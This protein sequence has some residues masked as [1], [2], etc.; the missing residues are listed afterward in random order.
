[1]HTWRDCYNNLAGFIKSHPQ[2]DI[3][4]SVVVI[5]DE[6]RAEFYD[7]F[8]Q[9]RAQYVKDA[10]PHLVD[11]SRLGASF[12]ETKEKVITHLK[13]RS[14]EIDPNLGWFLQDP[15][16]GLARTLFEPLFTLLEGKNSL[17]DFEL[18]A[19]DIISRSGGAW[20]HRGYLHWVFLALLSLVSPEGLDIVPVEDDTTNPDLTTADKRPGWYTVEVPKIVSSDALFLDSSKYTPLLVPKAVLRPGKVNAYASIATD[21]RSVYLNAE[22]PNKQVEWHSLGHLR[23]VFGTTDLWPDMALFVSCSEKNLEVVADYEKVVRPDVVI[24]VRETGNWNTP[25]GWERVMRHHHVMK[26]RLGTFL[27]CGEPTS[28]IDQSLDGDVHVLIT[29]LDKS[30]LGPVID[31]LAKAAR[32]A[33][34]SNSA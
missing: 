20:L 6:V 13:L 31:A 15:V 29:G 10:Y 9:V 12:F 14:V 34:E 33:A 8:N 17:E 23:Q 16:D 19:T 28:G 7:L 3:S 2:I 1:M 22:K 18:G 24:E 27:V 32:L 26:P 5:P 4:P 11:A 30:W 25:E 21:L